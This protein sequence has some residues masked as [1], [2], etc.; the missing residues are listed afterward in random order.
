[1]PETQSNLTTKK[2][3]K[4]K[5]RGLGWPS[6]ET[7]CHLRSVPRELFVFSAGVCVFR[8]FLIFFWFRV[9]EFRKVS[10]RN[11]MT[12]NFEDKDEKRSRLIWRGLEIFAFY[13][14]GQ[15][16]RTSCLL[17]T[18]PTQSSGFNTPGR[19]CQR[20]REPSTD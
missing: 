17:Q 6:N 16:C 13:R 1:M 5:S 19:R 18:A 4:T 15:K 3:K 2:Y 12:V 10:K 8:G 20:L 14:D 7:T 9:E 11:R